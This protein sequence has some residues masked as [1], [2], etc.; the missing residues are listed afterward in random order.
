VPNAVTAAALERRLFE[1]LGGWV[2]STREP[3]AKLLFRV[4]SFRHAGH[5]ELWES[6]GADCAGASALFEDVERLA[7]LQGTAARLR[8][9][10]DDVLPRLVTLYR[11]APTPCADQI[12]ADDDA[13]IREGRRVLAALTGEAATNSP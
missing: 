1:V 11:E 10:Y 2:P 13:A 7:V 12:V 3:E 9:A 6:A 4:Q 8:G 5:A